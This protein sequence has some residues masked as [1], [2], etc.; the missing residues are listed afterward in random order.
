[1]HIQIYEIFFHRLYRKVR[2]SFLLAFLFYLYLNEEKGMIDMCK[3]LFFSLFLASIVVIS[4]CGK[5]ENTTGNEMENTGELNATITDSATNEIENVKEVEL[6]ANKP[7]TNSEEIQ[8]VRDLLWEEYLAEIRADETRKNEVDNQVMAY[9]EVNMKYGIQI[10]GEPDE[11]G[12]PLYI[13]LHGGGASDTPETNNQQ[14]TQMA[15]YY[16]KNV[17]NGIYINP[18][19]V[20]DT[21]DTHG[22]PES[23]PLYDR[24]IENMIAF[25]DVD[26]NRVY[27][28]GFSA[29]GDGVYMI[30]PKMTDRFAAANMSAGHPNG[31]NL[32]NLYNMPIQLQVGIFDTAYNRNT[33]T[34]EYDVVLDKLA[35]TYGGGYL[36]NVFIHTQYGH[37]FYDNRTLEQEVLAD[38]VAWLENGDTTSVMANANAIHYLNQYTREAL[39][40]RVI[41]DFTNRASMRDVESFYWLS[42]SKDVTE[43]MI[44]ASYD[45]ETNSITIEENSANGPVKVLISNDMLDVFAPITV[46]TPSRSYEVTVTLE[47]DLLKSTTYERGDKNYQ[48]V[49]SILLE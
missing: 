39:P 26:P 20:R 32:A 36:H 47:Y 19:G 38:P 44:I 34:A 14:W 40:K 2:N 30:T 43:G 4:G 42:A 45:K 33:V 10:K 35:Q 37:N 27:L 29:G 6:S 12:Y 18:R 48:F 28:L 16:N 13:A 1:M 3:K 7:M 25:Y 49:A 41:W 23:Y 5:E 24:L 22:N 17:K 8:E 11:Q 9:G 21:W 15:L 46:N 31:I